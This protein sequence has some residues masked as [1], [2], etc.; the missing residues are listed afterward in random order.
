M[1]LQNVE[2]LFQAN[3]VPEAWHFLNQL[4]VD[5]SK[6]SDKLSWEGEVIV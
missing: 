6:S 5:T 4:S 3:L 1:K 2:V